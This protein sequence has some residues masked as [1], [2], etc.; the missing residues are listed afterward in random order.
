MTPQVAVQGSYEQQLTPLLR[1]RLRL[2]H[3]KNQFYV[4]LRAKDRPHNRGLNMSLPKSA[5]EQING[6]DNN[7]RGW[8]KADGDLRERLKRVGVR[9]WSIWDSAVT[10]HLYHPADVTMPRKANQQY[11]ERPEIP[12]RAANGLA[13]V[14]PDIVFST[15]RK[16]G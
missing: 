16:A 7:F 2:Q 6:Y 9:P 10:F 15:R 8:G 4:M 3:W 12:I 11:S 5:Y 1:R 14:R 13:E